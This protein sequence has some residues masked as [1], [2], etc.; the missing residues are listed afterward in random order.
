[1]NRLHSIARHVGAATFPLGASLPVLAAGFDK[2]DDTVTNVQTIP[3]T[4]S[5]AVVTIAIIWA[6]FKMD[7]LARTHLAPAL[8]R[9]GGGDSPSLT[10][11]GLGMGGLLEAAEAVSRFPGPPL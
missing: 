3:V 4:I 7:P 1:M 10:A 5:I 6:G 9:A 11:K 2:I 8:G